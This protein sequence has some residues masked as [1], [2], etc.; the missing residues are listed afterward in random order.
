MHVFPFLTFNPKFTMTIVE[1][2]TFSTNVLGMAAFLNM[3]SCM[4]ITVSVAVLILFYIAMYTP[5]NVIEFVRNYLKLSPSEKDSWFIVNTP[6]FIG[7]TA[8]ICRSCCKTIADITF[9]MCI[10][11]FINVLILCLMV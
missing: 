7:Y 4:I 3:V 2:L 8:V 10:V 9:W 11:F 6:P 5:Y 1:A